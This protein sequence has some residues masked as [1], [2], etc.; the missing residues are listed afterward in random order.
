MIARTADPAHR[1]RQ[2]VAITPAGRQLYRTIMPVARAMLCDVMAVLSRSQ[3]DGLFDALVALEG[4]T[5]RLGEA[6]RDGE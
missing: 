4:A 2:I 1:R 3:R 5:R 6:G